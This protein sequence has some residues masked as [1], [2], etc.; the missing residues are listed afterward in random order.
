MLSIGRSD[1]SVCRALP[2]SV[3]FGRVG[4]ARVCREVG[5]GEGA[6]DQLRDASAVGAALRLRREPAH[7]LAEIAGARRTGRGDR[8]GDQGLDRGVVELLGEGSRRGSRSRLPPSRRDPR[9]R[10]SGRPRRIRGG[11]SP[12]ARRSPRPRDRSARAAASSP[13]ATALWAI[14]STS[15]R[16]ASPLRIAAVTSVWIRSRRDTGMAT[17]GGAGRRRVSGRRADAL[18]RRGADR[19]AVHGGARGGAGR[20]SA[21]LRPSVLLALGFLALPLRSASRSARDGE[22]RRGCRTAGSSC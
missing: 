16:N 4:R 21:G 12:R 8:L 5:L 19:S 18:G 20:R 14:R 17:S 13:R 15:R 7:H 22:P 11:S 2:R 10:P 9:G 1:S 3:R 6:R